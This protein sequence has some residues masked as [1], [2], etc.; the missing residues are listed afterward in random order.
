MEIASTFEDIEA[1]SLL[2][3]YIF[4]KRQ[5][6][7]KE[8]KE[9]ASTFLKKIPNFY[10]EMKWEV[11]IPLLSFLCPSD[12]CK[13]W[14]YE[15]NV[16]LDYTFQEYR[17][18]STK[19]THCSYIYQGYGRHKEFFQVNHK[20]GYYY[21]PLQ[22]IEE[23]EK[24]LIMEDILKSRKING[25]FKI[26]QCKVTP[27]QGWGNKPVYEN[28]N[29]MKTQKYDV[30]VHTHIKLHNKEK[31]E[32][33][34]LNKDDYFDPSKELS[35]T[36]TVIMNHREVKEHLFDGLHVKNSQI[37]EHIITMGNDKQ[38]ALKAHVWIAED[39]PIKS[40]HL[41]NLLNSISNANEMTHKIKEFFNNKD[42]KEIIDKNGFP[43][44]I[45]IPINFFIDVTVH[46][47][48][49]REINENE[50]NL[51][52]LFEIPRNSKLISRHKA[53]NLKNNYKKR[54]AYANFLS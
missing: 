12:L 34:N 43:I 51:V 8:F 9:K 45:K 46:F 13:I 52:D 44:K 15:E 47:Q 36:I 53:E 17:N 29:R 10:M 48:N 28:V 24:L 19:R 54:I 49:F 5:K 40:S 2:F 33:E 42:I 4:S 1:V 35:K 20:L 25:E 16:R 30:N 37:K 18:L 41:V 31:I 6:K 39:F 3:D 50:P 22:P 23:D 26:K 7:I 14:K 32:Y 11:N 27:T 38:K 21:N